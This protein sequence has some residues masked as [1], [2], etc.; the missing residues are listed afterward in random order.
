MSRWALAW[1]LARRGLDWRFRGLRLL[2]VCL[3]LGTAALSAIGTLTGGIGRELAARGQSMLGGDLELTLAGRE[4]AANEL[5]AMRTLGTV[6]QGVR[7]Q[8]MARRAESADDAVPVELKAVD[9]RWPLYGAFTVEG[10]R[11]AGAPQGMTAWIDPGVGDRLGVKAGDRLKIGQAELVIGGVIAGE[12]DRLSEGFALGPTVIVSEEALKA[13]GLVQVGS[14]ARWKYRLRLRAEADPAALA[15]DFKTRFANSGFQVRT[16]D[17][18]SPGLDRF[19]S[20]MGQFLVLVALAALGIAGI[21]IAGGVSSYLEMRRAS[22]A[23]LKI[24]GAQSG[25]IVRIF[26]L[27]IAAA[28]AA[29]I[30]LGLLLGVGI[31]PLLARALEGLLPIPPGFTVDAGALAVAG[32]YGLLIALTF[33]APPLLEA[34]RVPAMALLRARVAPLG[35]G[36]RLP[37]WVLPV[38]L[39]L[40]G[41]AGLAVLTSPQPLLAAGF[42]GGAA[43][44]FAVLALIGRGLSWGA[45]R[46]PRPARPLLRMALGNLHRPGAQTSAL[47]VALGFALA[48]FVMLAAVQTSIDA[49]IAQRVPERA[50]DYFVL[51]VPKGA[52]QDTFRALVRREAPGAAVRMVP[53]MRGSILAFGPDAAMTEVGTLKDIPEAS[54]MLRGDRGLTYSADIPQGNVLTEGRWWPKDYA[55]EP[56]VSVDADQAKAI[57]LNVGDKVRISLLGTEREARVASLR[58]IDWSSFGFNYALVFSP[59]AL[60]DAPHTFAAT[61]TLAAPEKR[62]IV[63]RAILSGLVKALPESSVIEVGLVLGHARALLG[64]VGTAIFAAASVAVLAGLAVLAGAIAAARAARQYDSVI[65]RV[66]GASRAQLLALLAAEYALLCAVLALVALALGGGTAWLVIVQLFEFDWA[67]DWARVFAVLAGGVGLVMVLAVAGSL[68]V[69]RTRPAEALRAL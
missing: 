2:I 66:L 23:T 69:L 3:V 42:L 30:A 34:R 33:A 28:A 17:K 53:S 11:N 20:R 24:L 12:P 1:R 52:R 57:G 56:L 29:A 60:E 59:N 26:L 32:A 31:T 22:I 48:A 8:A 67:P 51:D 10:G 49:N 37:L 58:R 54:W 40:S 64:Q 47:V 36:W 7:L 61:I 44:V 15:E 6:S 14:M 65:L 18:A 63:R 19:V 39:G 16:R 9:A 68:S 62:E 38:G 4:A 46:L 25:D 5:A 27:Q 55:G 43:A 45:A 35:Q 50:P 21:G 13:S 41:I